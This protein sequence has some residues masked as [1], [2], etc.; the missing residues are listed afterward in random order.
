[1]LFGMLFLQYLKCGNLGM[2]CPSWDVKLNVHHLF[3]MIAILN[4]VG[5][6]LQG[7]LKFAQCTSMSFWCVYQVGIY[8]KYL[9]YSLDF[10]VILKRTCR[11]TWHILK[12]FQVLH[13]WSVCQTEMAI[14][15]PASKLLCLH[16]LE[17]LL[18]RSC[19]HCALGNAISPKT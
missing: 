19:Q 14:L 6:F 4:A 5:T 1:M 9:I 13:Q 3:K 10:K 8:K 15:R 12:Y 18:H 16:P 7:I 2:P 17:T 11:N